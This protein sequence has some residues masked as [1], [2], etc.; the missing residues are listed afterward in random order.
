VINARIFLLFTPLHFLQ[1]C[2]WR[3]GHAQPTCKMTG[4]VFL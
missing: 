1:V 4:S 3:S 2:I